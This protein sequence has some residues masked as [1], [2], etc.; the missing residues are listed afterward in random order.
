MSLGKGVKVRR[1]RFCDARNIVRTVNA[2][3]DGRIWWT[4]SRCSRLNVALGQR[5]VVRVPIGRNENGEKL[6]RRGG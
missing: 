4:C 3:T 1:C 6:L 5:E 2:A